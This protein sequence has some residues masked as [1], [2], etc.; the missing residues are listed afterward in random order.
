MPLF[1]NGPE[2]QRSP[3]LRAGLACVWAVVFWGVGGCASTEPASG[4]RGE[5]LHTSWLQL[6]GPGWAE[7]APGLVMELPLSPYRAKFADTQGVFY[8]AST[9]VVFRTRQGAVVAVPGGLYVK[10]AQ[11]DQ[12]LSWTE[13]VWR[14]PTMV[15]SHL[16]AVRR[17]PGL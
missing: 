7:V 14:Q 9:P 1:S 3:G 16:F 11:P 2:P 8:Q 12:A 17:H 4:L 10:H 13:P 5:V 15:Y 6:Q